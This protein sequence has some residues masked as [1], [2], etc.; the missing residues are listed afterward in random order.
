[1]TSCNEFDDKLNAY[2]DD[3]LPAGERQRVEAHLAICVACAREVARLRKLSAALAG[4]RPVLSGEALSRIHEAIAETWDLG[5]IRLA[6]RIS[7]VAAS[8]VLFGSLYLT[9]F[10]TDTA[11][12]G[13]VPA[14]EQAAIAPTAVQPVVDSA[15]GAEQVQLA[16]WITTDLA[17]NRQ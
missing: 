15:E 5:V 6:R 4:Y 10:A 12:A 8:V 14:W 16:T 11:T 17:G 3:E 2:V 9:F 7:A 1:M 13:A